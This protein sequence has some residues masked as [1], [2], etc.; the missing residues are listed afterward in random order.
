MTKSILD[1]R[2]TVALARRAPLPHSLDLRKALVVADDLLARWEHVAG[3]CGRVWTAAQARR[4]ARDIRR[5]LDAAELEPCD[6]CDA[7][8]RSADLATVGDCGGGVVRWCP[9]CRADAACQA[10]VARA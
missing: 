2:A 1:L 5:A 8:A 3:S 10:E 7:P 9:R 6:C 4:M